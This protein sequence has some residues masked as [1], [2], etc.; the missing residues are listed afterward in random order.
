MND[1]F[2]HA[3]S[4]NYKESELIK[5]ARAG[6]MVPLL[7]NGI[8]KVRRGETTL[9]EI[10]RVLGSQIK[11]DRQCSKC[12]RMVDASF[13]FCPYCGEFKKNFCTHCMMQLEEDWLIC[14]ACG[15][16][17]ANEKN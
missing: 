10:L 2:R 3:I 17:R 5:M 15:L 6:G 16:K 9:D 13:H 11:Y 8:E 14:P 12:Q 7:E 4:S 1:D